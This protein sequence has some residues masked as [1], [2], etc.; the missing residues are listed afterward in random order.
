MKPI[1]VFIVAVILPFLTASNVLA[2]YGA[3]AYSPSTQK[4]GYSY[5]CYS[6]AEARLVA[7]QN[8][9]VSDAKVV[10]WVHNG[11]AALAVNDTGA[12]GWGWSNY[13]RARAEAF[14]LSNVRGGGGRI[15]CWLA[16]GGQ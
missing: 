3:I 15:L 8:C 11:W 10:V 9:P 5:N 4:Y 13:S 6:L 7:L 16:S 14:A 1:R 12:Y 2:D